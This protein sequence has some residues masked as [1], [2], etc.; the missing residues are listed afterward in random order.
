MSVEEASERVGM[1]L[2]TEDS[3]PLAFW[4][5]VSPDAYLQL[6]DAVIV[7]TEVP[8]RGTVRTVESRLVG[9]TCR[10]GA[11]IRCPEAY[12]NLFRSTSARV[13]R[14][15]TS[16]SSSSPS[17]AAQKTQSGSS[18]ADRMYSRRQGAQSCFT[19]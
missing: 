8:G 1:V 3:T 6:D 11:T 7:D 16:R 12:G 4:V 9:P 13:P 10:T 2:G 14:C 15:T 17:T 5:A 18:S 19:V